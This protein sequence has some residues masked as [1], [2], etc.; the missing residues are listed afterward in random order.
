MKVILTAISIILL[1]VAIVTSAYGQEP[2]DSYPAF[3]SIAIE[4]LH[5]DNYAF[6]LLD[7]PDTN[8]Y[9]VYYLGRDGTLKQVRQRVSAAKH[10]LVKSRGVDAKRIKMVYRGLLENTSTI[11]L[12]PLDKKQKL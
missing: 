9:L 8:A 5:L 3:S 1:T 2:F 11:V 7:H 6:Y 4:R 12:Q 10:Y